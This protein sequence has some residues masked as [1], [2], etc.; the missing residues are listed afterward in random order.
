MFFQ[1]A[2][3]PLR[4]ASTEVYTMERSRTARGLPRFPRVFRHFLQRWPD[5]E[6]VSGGSS[7]SKNAGSLAGPTMCDLKSPTRWLTGAPVNQRVRFPHVFSGSW[8]FVAETEQ[9]SLHL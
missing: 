4:E 6:R 3:F 5:A 2:G 1:G 9:R 8:F 7:K